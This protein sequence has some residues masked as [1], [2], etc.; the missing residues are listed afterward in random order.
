MTPRQERAVP[1]HMPSPRPCYR[2]KQPMHDSLLDDDAL[3]PVEHVL[4]K[5]DLWWG[6]VTQ[7]RRCGRRVAIQHH[8]GTALRLVLLI[9]ALAV[10]IRLMG[11]L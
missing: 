7:H 1:T 8:V 4:V 6:L 2:C 9:A 5:V 3:D 10:F 11:G